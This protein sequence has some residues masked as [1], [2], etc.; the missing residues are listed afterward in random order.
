MNRTQL[1]G[2]IQSEKIAEENKAARDI[3]KEISAFGIN[4]RQ[5]WMIIYQ[6]ALEFENIDDLREV[7]AFIKEYKGNEIF[8]SN[9]ENADGTLNK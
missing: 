2:Q 9:K 7:T 3:V 1:Y 5:R 4:E 6:L 8:L